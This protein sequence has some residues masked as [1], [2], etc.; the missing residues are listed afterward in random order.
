MFGRTAGRHEGSRFVD[1]RKQCRS[2]DGG[3]DTTA[4]GAALTVGRSDGGQG[5]PPFFRG[6]TLTT[7]NQIAAISIKRQ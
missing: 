1:I 5:C 3:R 4:L 6:G 2:P 7:T